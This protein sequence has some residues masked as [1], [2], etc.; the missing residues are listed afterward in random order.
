MGLHQ[1]H[2][3]QEWGKNEASVQIRSVCVKLAQLCLAFCDPMDYNL[4]GSFV[5]G[6]L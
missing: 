2:K 6:I 3:D 4:P 5:H 1:K